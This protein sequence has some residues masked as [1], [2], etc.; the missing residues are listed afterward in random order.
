ME[1][2]SASNKACL[3]EDDTVEPLLVPGGGLLL[4]D[5]VRET[6]TR[7]AALAAGDTRTRAGHA[8]EE[9]H[10]KDTDTGVVLDTQ[11]N[12]LGDTETKVAG[13]GEVA[14][15][16]LV[17]LDLET[18]LDDLLGLGTTDGDVARDLL[19]TADTETTEGVAG[20]AGHRGLTGELL[21]HLGST[22][23]TVTRLTNGDVDDELVNLE[24]LL[25]LVFCWNKSRERKE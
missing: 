13:L 15:A 16:Q 22:G 5:A 1:Q 6:D 21:E 19:V 14:A 10:T 24:L 12:V 11:V 25:W 2:V 7:G 3:L 9:V 23:E 20:L 17:L 4:L 18:T 8:H